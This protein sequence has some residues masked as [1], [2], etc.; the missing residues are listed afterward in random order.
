MATRRRDVGA[1]EEGREKGG[2]WRMDD[3]LGWELEM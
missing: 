3:E 1:G 2:V